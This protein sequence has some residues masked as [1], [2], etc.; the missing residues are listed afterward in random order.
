MLIHIT[1]QAGRHSR[2]GKHPFDIIHRFPI[3]LFLPFVFELHGRETIQI[4]HGVEIQRIFAVHFIRTHLAL[5]R[6]MECVAQII[7]Y[8][9][10]TLKII[11]PF[12]VID[13]LSDR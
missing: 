11:Q 8:L 6:Q 7:V 2:V 5:R 4:I 1:Q 13:G 10:L 3:K 9:L 12:I